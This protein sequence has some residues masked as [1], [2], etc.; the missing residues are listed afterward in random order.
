MGM[1]TTEL[2]GGILDGIGEVAILERSFW[3]GR[4]IP[5]RLDTDESVLPSRSFRAFNA[6][7]LQ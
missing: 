2:L 5:T 1:D 6:I 7:N 3:E 4:G